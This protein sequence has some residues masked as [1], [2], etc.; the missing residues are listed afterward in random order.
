[1]KRPLKNPVISKIF[2]ILLLGCIISCGG[3][4]YENESVDETAE[5]VV[6]PADEW[7]DLFD[8][9][10]LNGWKRYN[11]DEIGPLWT[12]ED[13]T[14]KCDGTGLGEGSGEMGGSLVTLEKFGNFELEL[15]WKI[16]EGGNSG[17]MYHV[18]EMPEYGHAY[19]TGPEYQVLD[20]PGWKG[21]T[22]NPAQLVGSNYDMFAAPE[23]KKLNP[24]LEWNSSKIRYENGRVTHWLN[25]E[26]TVEFD[27]SSDEYKQQY[28]NSKW[29]EYPG[30]NK[31]EEG[32]IA[33][34]DHGAPVWY[35]N[36]RIRRL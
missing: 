23:D 35:R 22:L 20:D 5:T 31:Y 33:L 14:I 32:A 2:G 12:V 17:I 4:I 8:A 21:G 3:K 25:G 11:A 30:W 7:I 13:G 19:E 9:E 10:T 28:D 16:S 6:E 29:V 27:E 1:M 24:A 26:I 34:Q 18:V 15:E 36:I